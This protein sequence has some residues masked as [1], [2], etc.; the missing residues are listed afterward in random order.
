M[1]I[2][3]PSEPIAVVSGLQAANG[4]SIPATA[5]NREHRPFP[6]LVL[7]APAPALGSVVPWAPRYH[8]HNISISTM[9]WRKP[10]LTAWIYSGS[11]LRL[12]N[13]LSYQHTETLWLGN[14]QCCSAPAHL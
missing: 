3:P 8:T 7:G 10:H 4:I 13:V 6:S 9:A 14:T 11:R 2:I 1:F 5:R 12:G